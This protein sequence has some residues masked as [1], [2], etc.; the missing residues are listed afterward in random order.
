MCGNSMRFW[1]S[2]LSSRSLAS[3][4]HWLTFSSPLLR[5]G[6]FVLASLPSIGARPALRPSFF[7][8]TLICSP[9]FL[10]PRIPVPPTF[11]PRLSLSL[12]L[13]LASS[14]RDFCFHMLTL[15]QSL[16]SRVFGCRSGVAVSPIMQETVKSF[17]LG[18]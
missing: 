4:Y 14:T 1:V 10:C 7:R 17:L 9:L 5:I 6:R 15:P 8:T 11:C 12:S 2:S 18:R 16:C 13:Q 3:F